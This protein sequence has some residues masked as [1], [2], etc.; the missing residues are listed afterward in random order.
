MRLLQQL[1]AEQQRLVARLA[2]RLAPSPPAHLLTE[3]HQ[4][5]LAMELRASQELQEMLA[6]HP[7]APRPMEPAWLVPEDQEETD[8][9]PPQ[10]TME[11]AQLIGLDLL[12]SSSPPSRS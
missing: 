6:E 9:E 3:A 11:V 7:P 4:A 5:E 10:G 12:P 2:T 8:P 1:L